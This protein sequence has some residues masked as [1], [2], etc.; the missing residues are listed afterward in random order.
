MEVGPKFLTPEAWSVAVLHSIEFEPSDLG[1]EEGRAL[2]LSVLSGLDLKV[3]L[4]LSTLFQ[5]QT[6]EF[7]VLTQL[8]KAGVVVDPA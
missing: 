2:G 1:H 8:L 6:A 5:L 4:H 3:E 7:G